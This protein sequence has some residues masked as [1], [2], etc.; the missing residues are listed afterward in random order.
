ML[1]PP[2]YY[3]TED[4][5]TLACDLLGRE[6]VSRID[7]L[8]TKG[9]ITETEAYRGPE[10]RASHA[11]NNRRTSRTEI[12]FGPGGRAY[13]YLCYGIHQM[14]NVVTGPAETPHAILIRAIRP[15]EGEQI[16]L[17][18][19]KLAAPH[20]K[21]TSGPGTAAQALGLCTRLTGSPLYEPTS[22]VQLYEGN[23]RPLKEEIHSSPRIGIDYA[24]EDA[25]LP[26]RFQWLSVR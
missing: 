9:I 7:G 12:M 11:W 5:V 14:F 17:K 15:L 16:M 26:W 22:L 21:W 3:L 24:G 20:K 13:I 8:M 18:R 19:R 4:V 25:A 1:L 6:L 23:I 10:D 2:D